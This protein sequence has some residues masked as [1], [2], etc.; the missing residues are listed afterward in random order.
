[1]LKPE[2]IHGNDN[3]KS[4]SR[5]FSYLKILRQAWPPNTI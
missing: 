5:W 3:C 1:M 2:K 4:E